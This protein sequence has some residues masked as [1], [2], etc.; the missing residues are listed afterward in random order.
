MTSLCQATSDLP[1]QVCHLIR[2]GSSLLIYQHNTSTSFLDPVIC[3]LYLPVRAY[4]PPVSSESLSILYW[5]PSLLHACLYLYWALL[6]SCLYLY[7]ALLH[8]CLYCYWA[9]LH[10]CQ[11]LSPY[12]ALL[13][14]A[15]RCSAV[16]EGPLLSAR[17]G[18][19]S[20]RLAKMLPEQKLH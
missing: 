15:D 10:A 17:A 7:W 3:L 11:Y 5:A 20:R 13:L 2:A 16:S 6:H 8:S 12:W 18:L 19:A 14:A 9:L 4:G 1:L